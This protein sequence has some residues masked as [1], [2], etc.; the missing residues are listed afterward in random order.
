LRYLYINDKSEYIAFPKQTESLLSLIIVI[1]RVIKIDETIGNLKN[2]KSLSINSNSLKEISN[3]IGKLV[4]LEYLSIRCEN[5][6]T[7]PKEICDI[8]SINEIDLYIKSPIL[9]PEEIG[10]LENLKKFRWGQC[11]IFP[12][13]L[14][15]CESLERLTFD[16]SYFDSIPIGISNLF[17]LRRL[18][19]SFGTF[20]E[21]PADFDGLV[22]L[23]EL[24][25]TGSKLFRI[26][27]DL[28]RLKSLIGVDLQYCDNITNDK[29]LLVS[30]KSIEKLEWII[31]TSSH[32]S[33]KDQSMIKKE[34]GL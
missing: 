30:L 23:K 18:N 12:K 17:N 14:Y 16:K 25:L 34:L 10:Q 24:E 29:N 21:L 32:I 5:L 27:K 1:D 15:K 22:N 13:V 33:E 2:L 28:S 6:D 7:I 31:I 8:K 3:S 4:N 11:Q 19:L 9:F 26:P 20:K